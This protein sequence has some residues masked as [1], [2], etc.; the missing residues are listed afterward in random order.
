M[1]TQWSMWCYLQSDNVPVVSRMTGM[2]AQSEGRRR[3]PGAEDRTDVRNIHRQCAHFK[4]EHVIP[5]LEVV[6]SMSGERLDEVD[7][8]LFVVLPRRLCI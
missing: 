8:V 4:A 3:K 5:Q 7:Y 2:N 6:G 1:T